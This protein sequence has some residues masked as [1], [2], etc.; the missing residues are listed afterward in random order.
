[1]PPR[2]CAAALALLAAS[3]GVAPIAA[4]AEP[5]ADPTTQPSSTLL[6]RLRSRNVSLA[7]ATLLVD[8]L[9]TRPARDR[10]RASS[11]LRTT[12]LRLQKQYDK[13]A[14]RTFERVESAAAAQQKRQLGRKGA[15]EV[16]RH[17]GRSLA[18]SRQRSLSKQQIHAVCDPAIEQLTALLLPV[19]ATVE[20]GDDK[21]AAMLAELRAQRTALAQ[22]HELYARSTD[23][24]GL[25]PDAERHFSKY[26]PP[27]PP[28]LAPSLV[29]RMQFACFRGLPMAA[30]DRSALDHNEALKGMAEPEEYAGTRA[31][32]RIRYLLGLKL[33]RVDTKLGDAARDHSQDMHRLGFFAHKSPVEGKHSFGQRA[34]NFGTSAS[35]ENIARGQNSGPGAIRGWWYS[36]GHHRNMLGNHRRTGLGRHQRHWTQLFGR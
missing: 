29:A 9:C 25:H 20:A 12:F 7:A 28:P 10:L 18:V 27:N 22:W 30:G 14:E 21:L 32:N 3:A 11:T 13:L 16:E 34:A 17:R 35:A 6:V 2:I 5:S 26:P 8:A 23:G 36:P 4:Q 19:P 1:M 31:L 24:L 33:V 15:A